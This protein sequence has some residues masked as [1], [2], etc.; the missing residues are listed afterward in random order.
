[1][2]ARQIYLRRVRE[3]KNSRR[4]GPILA[5]LTFGSL[6]LILGLLLTAVGVGAA[7]AVAIYNFYAKDLP[8]PNEIAK[9]TSSSFKTTR[10]YDRTGNVLLYEIIDPL[11]GDRTVV[12]LDRMPAHLKNA[13]VAIEDKNFWDNPG[14]DWYGMGRAAWTT[15]RGEQVQGASTITQQL[16]KNVL[17][18][19]SERLTRDPLSFATYNRKIK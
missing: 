10:I 8:A 1:L 3:R 13:T 16:V 14:F 19:P 6:A 17:I 4:V 11:G 12:P 7:S 18:P 5:R 15:I 9:Q 2:S